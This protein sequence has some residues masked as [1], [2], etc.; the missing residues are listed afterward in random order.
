MNDMN[1]YYVNLEDL[2]ERALSFTKEEFPSTYSI[3]INP[4]KIVGSYLDNVILLFSI[5]IEGVFIGNITLNGYADQEIG[6]TSFFERL[7][8]HLFSS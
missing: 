5:N 7:H 6:S 4:P 2:K 1:V 8:I 3:D